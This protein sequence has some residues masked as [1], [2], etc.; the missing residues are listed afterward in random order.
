MKK[1]VYG[2]MVSLMLM[3]T[4]A[5]ADK[6]TKCIIADVSIDKQSGEVKAIDNCTVANR[7]V[8]PTKFIDLEV[9]KS[10]KS[11]IFELNI[12]DS[13][14]NSISMFYK[15]NNK[16]GKLTIHGLD[17]TNSNSNFPFSVGAGFYQTN[18]FDK[19]N[20]PVLVIQHTGFV[21]DIEI[22]DTKLYFG[23]SK[24]YGANVGVILFSHNSGAIR[25]DF[26]IRYDYDRIGNQTFNATSL[27][28][29]MKF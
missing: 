6:W 1:I 26:G 20:L 14:S 7:Y 22:S 25:T 29:K 16:N 8:Q 28:L 13:S 17:I 18:Y 27:N 5:S 2:T 12:K 19:K 15:E 10:N 24:H 4:G 9:S 21:S 11:E 23:N 3:V